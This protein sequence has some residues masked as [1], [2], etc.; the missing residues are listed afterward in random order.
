MVTPAPTCSTTPAPSWPSTIGCA[1]GAEVAVREVQVGVA[2]PRRCDAHQHLAG[3][4][5][6]EAQLLDP[7]RFAHPVEH[8]GADGDL[9]AHATRHRSR[10]SRSGSTPR[11]GPSGGAMV[12]SAA[13]STGAG[14]SQSRRSADHAGGSNGTST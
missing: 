11:P 7:H 6:V 2:D 3:A 12:P 13:I 1:I 4:G 8:G 9:A 14:S 10:A 5:R